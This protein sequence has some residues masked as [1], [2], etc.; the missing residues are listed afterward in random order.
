MTG[1]TPAGSSLESYRD[2]SRIWMGVCAL[3]IIFGVGLIA[4]LYP[5]ISQ[6]PQT[7]P[8]MIVTDPDSS[9]IHVVES[10]LV[11]LD[12]SL[13][14]ASFSARLN[15]SEIEIIGYELTLHPEHGSFW[16]AGGIFFYLIPN[17][18]GDHIEEIS[19]VRQEDRRGV[20]VM[21]SW[22]FQDRNARLQVEIVR[23]PQ[24]AAIRTYQIYEPLE[25]V[26][27]AIRDLRLIPVTNPHPTFYTRL[28]NPE[29]AK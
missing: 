20:A 3:L 4:W 17:D 9:P 22:V 23:V 2:D 15:E 16:E 28:L 11:Y 1:H 13:I 19:F 24:F 14:D 29:L 10:M 12:R 5:S 25:S 18:P 26:N 27:P 6:S 8:P 7:E 21:P